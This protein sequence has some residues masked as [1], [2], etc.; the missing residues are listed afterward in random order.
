MEFPE[1]ADMASTLDVQAFLDWTDA[2]PIAQRFI[3][4][5]NAARTLAVEKAK[6]K[7]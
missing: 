3:E 4:K 2:N 7:T 1:H 6:K 5:D